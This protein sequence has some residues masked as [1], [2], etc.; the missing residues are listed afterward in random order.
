MIL[1][2]LNNWALYFSRDSPVSRGMRWLGREA[3]PDL[4]DGRVDIDGERLFALV[5]TYPTRHPAHCR[6]EAHRDYL[7]IQ[8][9]VRGAEAIG[10]F[11]THVLDINEPYDEKRDII[12]FETPGSYTTLEVFAG[13]FALFYPGDAH[14][15]GMQ[16]IGHE[17]VK[18][19][20]VKVR[21]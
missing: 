8:Y 19:V 10:W 3:H 5:Q 4:P 7:D 21:L 14:M 20:V 1:D 6:F 9:I 17:E 15:P 11:P 2:H 13:G 12:F 18:K 16:M